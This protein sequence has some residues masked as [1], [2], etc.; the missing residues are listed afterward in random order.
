MSTSRV[1][2]KRGEWR[3]LSN[4]KRYL[5]RRGI[6]AQPKAKHYTMQ[7]PV[8]FVPPVYDVPVAKVTKKLGFFARL[9]RWLGIG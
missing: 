4:H 3:A 1:E 6:T 8:P 7:K 9:L 2:R 5:K